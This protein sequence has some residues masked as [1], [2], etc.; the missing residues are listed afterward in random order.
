MTAQDQRK[1]KAGCLGKGQT[2][3]FASGHD[4]GRVATS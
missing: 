2:G 3:K 4:K 1:G